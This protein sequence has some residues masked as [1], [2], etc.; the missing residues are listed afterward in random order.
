MMEF[1][2][3]VIFGFSIF[4]SFSYFK[5]IGV[6]LRYLNLICDILGLF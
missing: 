2:N 1:H 4:S 3:Y 6:N 5:I